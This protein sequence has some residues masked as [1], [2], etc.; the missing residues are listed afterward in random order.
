MPPGFETALAQQTALAAWWPHPCSKWI[1]LDMH[2]FMSCIQHPA[3]LMQGLRHPPTALAAHSTTPVY[4]D[5][6][7][8]LAQSCTVGWYKPLAE[9]AL[10]HSLCHIFLPGDTYTL[11]ISTS[12]LMLLKDVW[13]SAEHLSALPFL[14]QTEMP[15]CSPPGSSQSHHRWLHLQFLMGV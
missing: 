1:G 15:H 2:H 11:I 7:P 12:P 10:L 14:N 4:V 5:T 9:S 13:I 6:S 3:L 8:S